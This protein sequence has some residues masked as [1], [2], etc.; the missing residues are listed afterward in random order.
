MWLTTSLAES[1]SSI[2]CIFCKM[3][4]SSESRPAGSDMEFRRRDR[5]PDGISNSG[6]AWSLFSVVVG[7]DL[8]NKFIFNL[9]GFVYYLIYYMRSIYL[10]NF[11]TCVIKILNISLFLFHGCWSISFYTNRDEKLKKWTLKNK[12]LKRV[13]FRCCH[14]IHS[15]SLLSPE[16][17]C[18][19][20]AL[21]C[22]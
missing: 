19:F 4:I 10:L 1:P 20:L 2:W 11:L 5:P 8:E 16:L 12:G 21:V 7:D 17:Y 6:P 13:S 3:A 15:K 18:L 9:F 14:K 22:I